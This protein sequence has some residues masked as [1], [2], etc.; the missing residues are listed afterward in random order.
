VEPPSFKQ[1]KSKPRS[2]LAGGVVDSVLAAAHD[3]VG[4]PYVFGSGPD[5]SS[6]DCSDLIQWAY[7]Q[8]GIEIPRTT[9]DQINA[10]V[11]V[12]PKNLEPGDLVFPSKGHVVMYVGGGKVIAAPRTGT[13]VQYQPLSRFKNIVAARRIVQ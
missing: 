9:F 2:Q 5:T 6:F 12:N 11:A 8:I 13:V 1:A 10:G 7:K 4:K 3:Q